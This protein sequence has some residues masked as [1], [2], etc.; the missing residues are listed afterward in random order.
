MVLAGHQLFVAGPPDIIDEESTFQ[1]LTERDPQVQ[2][3]LAEQDDALNGGQGGLLL[4]VDAD[5]G[6]IAHQIK[7]E[8]L[9]VWDGLAG[10]NG[11]LFLSTQDGRVICYGKN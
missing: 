11:R 9:P 7:L 3:L 8:T 1:K 4:A 5:T 10:A 6:Q 2:Q